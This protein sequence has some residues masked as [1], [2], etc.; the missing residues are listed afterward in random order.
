MQTH[1]RGIV[2]LEAL[3]DSYILDHLSGVK[4]VK[5]RREYHPE[6]DTKEWTVCTVEVPA[7]QIGFVTERIAKKMKRGWYAKFSQKD[8]VY[9]AARDKVF[10]LPPQEQEAREYLLKTGV[11]KRFIDFSPIA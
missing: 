7:D 4:L 9:I 8:T 11:Q 6:A 1:F 3:D 5:A 2:E 10:R